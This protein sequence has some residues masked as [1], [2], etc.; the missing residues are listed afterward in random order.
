VDAGKYEMT[1]QGG[2]DSNG[3]GFVVTH[4]THKNDIRILTQKGAQRLTE[5]ES[6]SLANIY[7][8]NAIQ[9][10]LHWILGSQYVYLFPVELL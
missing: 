6:D 9:L 10:V 7:L 5:C 3:G 1:G 8:C 4:F 2:A